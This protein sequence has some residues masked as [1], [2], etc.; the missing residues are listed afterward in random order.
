[1]VA[2]FGFQ[3]ANYNVFESH[4]MT[5]IPLFFYLN[6]CVQ[7][8]GTLP[9]PEKVEIFWLSMVINLAPTEN[10]SG[11]YDV[12]SMPCASDARASLAVS[13]CF[14]EFGCAVGGYFC[15]GHFGPPVLHL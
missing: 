2:K 6:Y 15:K 5:I 10:F 8:R 14:H 12:I 7:R 3:C 11:A 1:M 13:T 9:N 4:I